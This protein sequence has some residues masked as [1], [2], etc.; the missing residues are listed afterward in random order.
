MAAP[1]KGAK[2]RK[3]VAH[4]GWMGLGGQMWERQ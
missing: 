4:T 2:V 1:K 3:L